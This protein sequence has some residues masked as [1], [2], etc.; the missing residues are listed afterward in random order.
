MVA[1]GAA[2]QRME[3]L[4]LGVC[5]FACFNLVGY[6]LY[7]VFFSWVRSLKKLLQLFCMTLNLIRKSQE[8]QLYVRHVHFLNATGKIAKWYKQIVRYPHQSQF[9]DSDQALRRSILSP[10]FFLWWRLLT[11]IGITWLAS[12]PC[13]MWEAI[14]LFFHFCSPRPFFLI[15]LKLCI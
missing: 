3:K 7:S 1:L 14:L 10:P 13:L 9:Q 11:V 2:R 12:F 15:G 5:A 6:G 4:V 8:A